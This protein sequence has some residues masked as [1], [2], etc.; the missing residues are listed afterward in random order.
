MKI[1][2]TGHT[3]GVGKAI[4]DYFTSDSTNNVIGVSRSNGF[5]ITKVSSRLDIIALAKDADIFV[6]SAYNFDYHD[7]SQTN[8]LQ[9]LVHSWEGLT[10]T[11]INISTI[12]DPS[13]NTGKY[14]LTKRMMDTFCISRINKIPFIINIKPG[15]IRIDRTVKQFGEQ[16]YMETGDL[17]NVL[18]F[19]LKSNLKISTITFKALNTV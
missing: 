3:R 2:I 16:H 13:P 19:C 6:N 12:D 5:D 4:Y 11:I 8:M 7:E 14:K 1:V 10:K 17:I 18:D 15:W 9:E